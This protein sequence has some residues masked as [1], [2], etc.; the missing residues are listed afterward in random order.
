M[1]LN[2]AVC[3]KVVP[4]PDQYDRIQ[5]DP[6][7]KTLVRA[8]VDSVINSADLHAIELALQLKGQYGGKITL[9]SMG[10]GGI[11]PQLREGL[12]YGCDAAVLVSD[13]KF[14]GADS[15]ATSY[16]LAKTVKKL[17]GFDLILLGN[18]SDNLSV[19]VANAIQP[20]KG[21]ISTSTRLIGKSNAL[22]L[23]GGSAVV[24][25]FL[26]LDSICV[27]IL[28]L[29][30]KLYRRTNSSGFIHQIANL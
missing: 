22:L 9:V 16:T 13:R 7:T 20:S 15:L 25:Q 14:G 12:S 4:N 26:R 28:G 10:P 3:M 11:E 18:A 8:G 30:L 24:F 19:G 23:N 5:L 6:V 2:I 17:G 1:A 27:F 29:K 21:T